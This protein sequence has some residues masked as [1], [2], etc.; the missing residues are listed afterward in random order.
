MRGDGPMQALTSVRLWR[1]PPHA[2]G[3]TGL[4]GG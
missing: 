3:W 1:F 2:R 4:S